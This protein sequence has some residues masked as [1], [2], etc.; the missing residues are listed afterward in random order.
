MVEYRVVI[1]YLFSMENGV[2]QCMRHCGHYKLLAEFLC[3][4]SFHYLLSGLGNHYDSIVA[5]LKTVQLLI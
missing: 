2:E 1:S 3:M 4:T 5:T